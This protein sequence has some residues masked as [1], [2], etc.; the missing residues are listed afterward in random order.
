VKSLQDFAAAAGLLDGRTAVVTGAAR[1][2]GRAIAAG[3]AGAGAFVWVADRDREGAERTVEQIAAAGGRAAALCW[4]IAGADHAVAAL[5]AIR[6][7]EQRISILVNNAGIEAAGRAGDPGYADSWRRVLGVNLDGTMLVT[8]A[9]LP[10]L[11]ASRGCIVNVASVQAFVALQGGASAY[12]ASKGA[13]VQYT[14]SLAVE[15][16]ASHVRVNAIAPGFINTDMTAGTRSDA[17]SYQHFIGRT[18]MRRFGD[19]A[20]LVGPVL[21]LVS[22]LSSYVTGAVLPVDGGL[23]AQ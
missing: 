16:A 22:S 5:E 12:A 11:I 1:G 15:L 8:E 20:E 6:G 10:D 3:L 17:S 19:P 2:N 21:F 18:P 13:L 9:L 4:D 7:R 23:L 14:R